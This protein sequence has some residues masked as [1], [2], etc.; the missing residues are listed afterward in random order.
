MREQYEGELRIALIEG[1]LAHGEADALL[2]EAERLGRS[3]LDLL[4]ERGRLSEQTRAALREEL[5]D[6]RSQQHAAGAA[7]EVV[8]RALPA[9]LDASTVDDDS[10]APADTGFPAGW[11]RYQHLRLLG[12]GGMGRVFL[13]HDP[14]LRRNVAIKFML[15]QTSHLVRRFLAEARAQARVDHAN[16]C[17]VYEVGEV[18]RV[19]GL[20]YIAMQYVDGET[21]DA[22]A[23]RLTLE[24]KVVL[25]RDVAE[26]LHAA[27]RVG[28][29]HR[30][31]KPSNILVERSPEGAY[32]AYVM[33][34]GLV[35]DWNEDMTVTGA[36]LGTPG[37]MAPE[38]ARGETANL[39][40]RADVYGLGATMY[41][42]LTGRR[43]IPGNHALEVL[44]NLERMEPRPPRALDPDIP[45]DL[46]AIVLQCLEKERT[47]RYDSARAVA[48]DLDR[49]L[50][51]EPVL[52]RRAGRLYRLRKRAHRH[53][54]MLAVAGG[55]LLVVLLALGWAG[56]ARREAAERER[57]ARRFTEKVE[58]IE[59]MARYSSLAPLHDTRADQRALEVQIYALAA[60]VRT[61]GAIAAGPGHYALGRG[62]LALGDVQAAREHLERAWRS[63]YREPRVAYALALVLGRLYQNGLL[64][65]ARI[66]STERREAER[67]ALAQRWR[68]PALAYL[69]RSQGAD[70]PSSEY[71]AALLAYYE[72]RLDDALAHL[73]AVGER[74]PW[75][76][77]AP[78]LE[79][80]IHAA[81]ATAHW[82]RGDREAAL[83]DFERAR[84]AYAAAAA[85]GRSDPAVYLAMADAEYA[86]LVMALYGSG[87]PAPH[88]ERGIEAVSQALEAAPEH[89]DALVLEAR[90]HRRLAEHRAGGQGDADT[91]LR[92]ALAAA[93][94]AQDL[95]P[96]RPEAR[97]E[98]GRCWLQQA[99]SEQPRGGDPRPWLARAAEILEG[100]EAGARDYDYYLDLGVLYSLQADDAQQRGADSLGP[101]D[102]AI[103]A[104]RAAVELD[105]RLP[106]AWAS[107]GYAYLRRSSDARAPE[108]EGDLARAMDALERARAYNP[109]QVAPYFYAALTHELRGQRQRRRGQDPG[110]DLERA[111]ALYRAGIDINGNVAPLHDGLGNALLEQAQVAWERGQAPWPLLDAAMAA[112]QRSME[113]A[114][115]QAFGYNNLGA[116]LAFRARFEA[117][118]GHDAMASIRASEA[119]Y[120]QAVERMP[121]N[122]SFLVNL[123]E[124][125]ALAAA[126]ALAASRD[127]G[128]AIARG[129][130]AVRAALDVNPDKASA[131]R[132]LGELEAL[133]ARWQDIVD[134]VPP[135]RLEQVAGRF[136][137][138]IALAPDDVDHR[139]ALCRFLSWW[140]A[141]DA[142][143]E[144][145]PVLA[146]ALGR[147]DEVLRMWPGHAEALALRGGFLLARAD[148][149][150]AGDARRRAWLAE[151]REHLTAALVANPHL[152]RDWQP[153]MARAE[154]HAVA[155]A[156]SRD[157]AVTRPLSP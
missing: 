127:P 63:G 144:V 3:P 5:P 97:L 149:A 120:R 35:R 56:L 13:A 29:I 117:A 84:Q 94:A 105:A 107:L 21:L 109:A 9:T 87:D 46:E 44:R 121:G 148:H 30:D 20:A 82:H 10:D 89:Y 28:L 45:A 62:Y 77:E 110:P 67:T 23:G 48:E 157:G 136:E 6:T 86:A 147:L 79:G 146:R 41:R 37:Y 83:A 18:D 130:G 142:A 78:K 131:W 72:E 50:A 51:A 34:F 145:E 143:G 76:Y 108:L 106:A 70:A 15:D 14:R 154:Q 69:R 39:D 138:A 54:R 61:A 126:H 114:P 73:H 25:M 40:R 125:H 8:L 133:G 104:Y 128:A 98:L 119:A 7:P 12:Q 92:T 156:R 113:V 74:L 11:D 103:A 115:G 141:R 55:A 22:L 88:F 49:F 150:P 140:S 36:V 124:I 1:V 93:R 80:D 31:V 65:A 96:A 60:E 19:G 43:P 102:R 17:K 66:R 58:R 38:Q 24:Q 135:E 52:A 33:D 47:A 81:R 4:V 32:K 137:R 57:L 112:Y 123:A 16:V 27:H 85:T 155:M 153:V 91:P 95:V 64:E 53:R 152:V 26:G 129:L 134:P 99:Q 2:G 100:I 132:F 71:V 68:E 139:L 101:R 90:L 59:A 122:P 151:A 116:A 118:L 75:F 42:L 111:I